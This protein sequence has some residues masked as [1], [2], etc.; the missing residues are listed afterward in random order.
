V[1]DGISIEDGYVRAAVGPGAGINHGL[2]AVRLLALAC[3]RA[4]CSR[5]LIVGLD[6]DPGTHVSVTQGIEELRSTA[7]GHCLRLAL[8]AGSPSIYE[9]YGIA[10]RAAIRNGMSAGLFRL[11]DQAVRWLLES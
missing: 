6:D 11:E 8:V 10:Q 1:R 4:L 7:P 2:T 3:H 9:I 5:G